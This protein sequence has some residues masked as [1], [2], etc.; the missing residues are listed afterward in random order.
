MKNNLHLIKKNINKNI[1][2]PNLK[3]YY[4]EIAYYVREPYKKD[5]YLFH[6]FSGYC[7]KMNSRFSS[8]SLFTLRNKSLGVQYQQS[9]FYLQPNILSLKIKTLNLMVFN[10]KSVFYLTKL[11]L[12]NRIII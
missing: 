5:N 10:K 11:K 4:L 7:S 9:F 12:S 6:T 1:I 3:G 8:N 2:L